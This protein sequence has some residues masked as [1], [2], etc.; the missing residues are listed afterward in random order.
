MFIDSQ[1][2]TIVGSSLSGGEYVV[3]KARDSVEIIPL[4][5]Y[6]RVMSSGGFTPAVANQVISQI[7][8]GLIDIDATNLVRIVNSVLTAAYGKIVADTIAISTTPE[9]IKTQQ[10]R[11]KV[12]KPWISEDSVDT[13]LSERDEAIKHSLRF[14]NTTEIDC[15]L[16]VSLFSPFNSKN[17]VYT[18]RAG[19]IIIDQSIDFPYESLTINLKKGKLLIK[20]P[21]IN[22]S[23]KQ[24]DEHRGKF[25]FKMKQQQSQ[26]NYEAAIEARTVIG[27]NNIF[28]SADLVKVDG[29]VF[30]IK[31]DLEIVTEKGVYFLAVS[32]Y[33]HIHKHWGDKTTIDETVV[34]QVISEIRAGSIAIKS[35][36]ELK[37]IS[38]FFKA[39]SINI[40]VDRLLLSGEKEIFEKNIYFEG[41]KKYNGKQNRSHEHIRD[42][43]VVPTVMQTGTLNIR[44]TNQ[45]TI[46]AAQML[47]EGDGRISA[48]GIELLAKYNVH[49]YDFHAKKH[50]SYKC[51]QGKF[52][53][54]GTK[55][56]KEHF[57]GE[58]PI[59]TIYYSQGSF[60][61]FSD[62]QIHAMGAKIVGNDIYLEG[63]GG[64]KLE[65]APY[66][67]EHFVSITDKGYR[68]GYNA[69]PG[70]VSV[71]GELFQTKQSHATSSL[72]HDPTVLRAENKMVITTNGTDANIEIISTIMDA[73]TGEISTNN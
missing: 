64:I 46:E 22:E 28:I 20:S 5:V 36:G 51:H 24:K 45:T 71:S 44:T 60:F 11:M 25:G 6:N 32:V 29:G 63:K 38:T 12:L 69:G 27:G 14:S 43:V 58:M 56:I 30:D 35:K 23:Y 1:K 68:T 21:Q 18:K 47:V 26:G 9:F 61:C 3:I 48:G 41:K 70:E 57:Y 53:V 16:G 2:C 39:H 40:K 67:T 52:K 19:D 4:T 13:V 62:G 65:P 49:A 37:A 31:G 10:E 8:T 73:Q 17:L 50:Y 7:Q 72:R 42:E 15:R 33:S 66:K 59:P 34:K 55:T 54:S